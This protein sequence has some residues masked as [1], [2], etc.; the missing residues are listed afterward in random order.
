MVAVNDTAMQRLVANRHGTGQSTL[1]AVMRSTGTLLAGSTVVVAGYGW[2]GSGIAERA[3]GLGAH[4]VV[5]EVDPQR[6][7][8]AV[9]EGYRVLPMSEAAAVGDVFVTVTGNR[10][11]L[12]DG[13]FALMRDGA[14]LA[15]AGHFD[16]EIDVTGLTDAAVE[17]HRRVRP[18]VDEYVLPDG[19]RLLLVAEGRLANL[20]AAEGHPAAVMDMSFAVQALTVEW[21]VGTPLAPGVHDVPPEI[22]AEVA[23]TKLAALGVGLDVLSPPQ[24]RY[25][26][27]WQA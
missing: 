26:S 11:V 14:V 19:R 6:A 4:V 22:D 20:A 10:D 16:V 23:R 3:R 17:V 27:T 5:T 24:E 13:H 15:N 18:H 21:L 25:L 12:T 1:D 8:A 9:L 2:C 7:L